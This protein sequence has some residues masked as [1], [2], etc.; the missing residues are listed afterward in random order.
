MTSDLLTGDID[1]VVD[2]DHDSVFL[3]GDCDV[4]GFWRSVMFSYPS[5]DCC[6]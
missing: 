4:L 2:L 3:S 1:G 6:L 5:L